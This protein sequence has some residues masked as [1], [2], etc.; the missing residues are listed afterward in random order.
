[1]FGFG[2]VEVRWSK[3]KVWVLFGLGEVWVWVLAWFGRFGFGFWLGLGLAG[4]VPWVLPVIGW[5]RFGFGLVGWVGRFG[6]GLGFMCWDFDGTRKTWLY[7][8]LIFQ[9]IFE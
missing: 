6:F 9:F 7:R 8:N 2:A 4:R 5:V 3:N 1:M